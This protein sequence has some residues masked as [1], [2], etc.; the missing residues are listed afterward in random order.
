MLHTVK[1]EVD[2]DGNVQLLE[3]LHVTKL[4]R[5]LVTLLDKQNGSTSQKGNAADMLKFLRENRLPEASR[6]SEAEIEA[7][8][9]EMRKS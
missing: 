2:V 1:A 6:P 8:I 9:L 5:A 7:Q 3:P 4:S